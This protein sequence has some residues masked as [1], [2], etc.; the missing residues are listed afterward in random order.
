[1]PRF[2]LSS[3]LFTT[4]IMSFA[5]GM[6]TS[7]ERRAT[8]AFSL[9][10]DGT[11]TQS[12]SLAGNGDIVLSPNNGSSPCLDFTVPGQFQAKWAADVGITFVFNFYDEP[13]CVGNSTSFLVPDGT[14]AT[15]EAIGNIDGQFVMTNGAASMIAYAPFDQSTS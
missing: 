7:L 5:T 11:C 1:M 3:F 10:N 6:P 15:C 13:G 2:A 8:L 14:T 4:Y 9:F 12:D